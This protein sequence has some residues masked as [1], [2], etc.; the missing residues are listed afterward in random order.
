MTIK[1]IL[2][3]TLSFFIFLLGI[4][5]TATTVSAQ[6]SGSTTVVFQEGLNGYT[7]TSDAYI[8]TYSAASNF[9]TATSL[10]GAE[11][12]KALFQFDLSSIPANATVSNATLELYISGNNDNAGGNTI[13]LNRILNK[14]WVESQV[15]WNVYATG[16]N[17]STA[18][19]GAGTDYASSANASVNVGYSPANVWAAFPITSLAQSW[20]DGTISNTGVVLH[21][22]NGPRAIVSSS[23]SGDITLRPKLTITYTGGTTAPPPSDTTTPSTPTGLS[24]AVVS[25]SQIN[26]S[27]TASTDNVGVTGYNVYRNGTPIATVA[28]L[29][30]NDTALTPNTTYSYTVS[31]YDAAGYSSVQ[32]ASASATTQAVSADTALPTIPTG[33]TATAVSSSQINLSWTAS[34]DN[35]GVTG[36]DIYRGGTPLTTV[37]AT[38]YSNTGLTASTLYSYTVRAKDAAGNNSA[39]TASVSA[40]TQ[41]QSTTTALSTLAASMQPGTWAELNTQGFGQSLL[42]DVNGSF[43]VQ[44]TDDAQWDPIARQVYFIGASYGFSSGAQRGNFI[45]YNEATNQWTLMPRPVPPFPNL[46]HA[47][48]H[49]ALNPAT[50]EFYH[51][52][53]NDRDIYRYNPATNSWSLL[54]TIPQNIMSNL[55]ITKG[56]E[57]FPEMGGLVWYSS[58]RGLYFYNTSTNQWSVLRS[59]DPCSN[60]CY[61]EFTEYDPVH[62]IILFGGGDGS[63][64]L[65]KLDSL[66]NV[67]QMNNPPI[68]LGI[69]KSIITVDPVSGKFLVATEG[70]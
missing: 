27:W 45:K 63:N 44:Y 54:T 59:N 26:L 55:Q 16:N 61:H 18:G 39:Q 42:D 65:Y 53:Y 31:A 50:G 29:S 35:I 69:T 67:T 46:A 68:G 41:T 22:G 9:G 49:S 62:K 58:G 57:Y 37:A 4:A 40:T 60:N 7:G 43:I 51:S 11:N 3:P 17:W 19:L 13:F 12:Q 47:Y 66:G 10:T 24:A 5:T 23:E 36:Y 48:D 52:L 25:S 2:I 70:N 32:S 6:V 15:T 14:N 56:L 28:S 21:S 20:V 34:T 64:A 1:K 33:L 30:Y 8:N 38:S